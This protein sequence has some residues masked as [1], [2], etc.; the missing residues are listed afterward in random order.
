[1]FRPFHKITLLCA[2]ALVLWTDIAQA[3]WVLLA[4]RAIGRVEQMSQTSQDGKTTYDTATVMVEVPVDRVYETVQRSVRA[5]QGITVT[6]EDPAAR[7]IQFTNGTQIAGIQA[8]SLGDN[9]TQLMVSSAHS[10]APSP[11]TSIIVERIV[12]TCK[13][14]NVECSRAP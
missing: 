8:V 11:P 3:Q 1:L 2:I 6:N 7:R 9:L 12:A 10:N 14:M 5:A 13:E 4:R